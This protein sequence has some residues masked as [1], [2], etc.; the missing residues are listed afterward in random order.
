[1]EQEKAMQEQDNGELETELIVTLLDGKG[2]PYEATILN[3][4]M[5]G[6]KQYVSVLPVEPDESGEFP[7]IL[8]AVS[9]KE[10]SEDS[11][12]VQIEI[13]SIPEHEYPMIAEYY[14]RNVLP[15]D[16]N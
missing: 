8:F 14:E 5:V 2:E 6:E 10:D 9:V 3:S 13:T 7:I 1:M 4:F 11:G 15:L 16:M 12:D